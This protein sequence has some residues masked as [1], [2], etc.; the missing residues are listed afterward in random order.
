MMDQTWTVVT[1]MRPDGRGQGRTISFRFQRLQMRWDQLRLGEL[2]GS[3]DT[4]SPRDGPEELGWF[5]KWREA[6][7]GVHMAASG[8]IARVTGVDEFV[9][10]LFPEGTP[11]ARRAADMAKSKLGNAIAL[12][13]AIPLGYMP[14]RRMAI[15]DTDTGT[16]RYEDPTASGPDRAR[17]GLIERKLLRVTETPAGRMA[18]I[19]LTLITQPAGAATPTRAP[20]G[21]LRYDLDRG[22][23]AHMTSQMTFR[24]TKPRPGGQPDMQMMEGRLIE[25]RMEV[26]DADPATRPVARDAAQVGP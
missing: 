7:L 17:E 2:S 12:I 8:Q 15:G 25:C 13:T 26:L 18:E 22:I 9:A 3:L 14:S 20:L 19:A 24:N 11:A 23:I 1:T 6:D 21:T 4:D 16:M 10:R 5:L